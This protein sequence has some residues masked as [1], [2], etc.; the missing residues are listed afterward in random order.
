[1]KR[2]FFISVLLIS[3]LFIFGCENNFKPDGEID[4][5][6][7]L[8]VE[9]DLGNK[10][11]LDKKPERIVVTSAAF[12]EPLH[13]VGA[14]IVG[15]PDSKN[16]TP[17]WAKDIPSV[18]QVY[19]I[20]I[21]KLMACKPDLVILN[22]GMNEKNL[23][24]L[25]ENKI[26]ALVME[27]KTY[28]EV[29][30][31]LEIFSKIS[32]EPAKGEKLNR[33]MDDAIRQILNK[34]PEEKK[35]VIILHSTAQGLTVQLN[36]SIAGNI[37]NMLNW[38]NVAADMTPLEKRPDSA[39]YSIET[40]AEKNPEII[41]ITSMG[42]LEEIKSNMQGII[43]SNE[44]WQT[45]TAVKNNHVYYLPQDMFLLSPGLDY[46][47]AVKIMVQLVYPNMLP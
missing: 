13:A 18:G 26:P 16:K 7:F 23:S 3:V 4:Q 24:I 45:L 19:Q 14:N 40:L 47:K 12:L 33:D 36:G 8:T 29:K 10:V 22:K 2:V 25:N 27:M 38:E 39:S 1:M 32:G 15:R 44:V 21:E 17:D 31:T 42:N 46:P 43:D 20:D 37:V 6:N 35:R 41:F 9:D 34:L 5:Q 28:Q 11:I 30:H